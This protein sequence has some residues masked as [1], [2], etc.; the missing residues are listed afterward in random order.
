MFKDFI[1]KPH[2]EAK[3]IVMVHE[4]DTVRAVFWFDT[5]ISQHF[6]QPI[7]EIELHKDNEWVAVEGRSLPFDIPKADIKQYVENRLMAWH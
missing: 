4:S 5:T 3:Q 7:Y 1:Y 6:T 2:H